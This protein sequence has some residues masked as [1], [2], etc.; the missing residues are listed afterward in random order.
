M[1]RQVINRGTTAGDGT[2]ESLFSAFGKANDNFSELYGVLYASDGVTPLWFFD[3]IDPR[4]HGCKGNGQLV[5]DANLTLV[6][7][8]TYNIASATANN[9]AGFVADDIGK[10]I[11]VMNTNSGSAS[12]T[13]RSGTITSIVNVNQA[14]VT[15]GNVPGGTLTNMRC[16]FGTD[17]TANFQNA[18][19]IAAQQQRPVRIAAIYCISN[20][21]SLP[22]D[23][24]FFGNG[25]D[26]KRIAPQ[27]APYHGGAIVCA[28]WPGNGVSMIVAGLGNGFY[29]LT[30]DGF[31]NCDAYTLD[32]ST[33]L[34]KAAIGRC[35]ILSGYNAN[36][37]LGSTVNLTDSSL[38]M[39]RGGLS[40]NLVVNGGDNRI[41]NCDIAGSGNNQYQVKITAS[42]VRMSNCHS[43]KNSELVASGRANGGQ[44][45]IQPSADKFYGVDINDH[46]HDTSVGAFSHVMIDLSNGAVT[47]AYDISLNGGRVFQAA[48]SGHMPIVKLNIPAGK[49]LRGFTVQGIK[50]VADFAMSESA[51]Y[52]YLVDG[53]GVA[54]NI[55][56]SRTGDCNVMD[57]AALYNFSA[58]WPAWD[59]ND[60]NMILP[61]YAGTVPTIG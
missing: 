6:S 22:N 3:A 27:N 21:T 17:D 37:L 34:G 41:S 61:T 5:L 55:Y 13:A 11:A 16:V 39:H 23:L 20:L 19:T 52:T 54:G 50:G 32:T 7:G 10:L 30:L 15:F 2:G 43:W 51:Q 58:A 46:I 36:V 48:S 24:T 45:L 28:K 9:G 1:A 31:G 12:D 26:Q 25:P 60:G 33:N 14:Q 57:C 53:S 4:S 47:N 56:A 38:W 29:H 49:A 44:I 35:M 42:E 8:T 40:H 59:K 18:C